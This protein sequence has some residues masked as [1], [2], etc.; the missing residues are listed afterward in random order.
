MCL[1][2]LA[3][4][5]S[6]PFS[7]V[8]SMFVGDR[9]W[10]PPT[11]TPAQKF[12]LS[13]SPPQEAKEGGGAGLPLGTAVAQS[14]SPKPRN[15]LL[16]KRKKKKKI[17]AAT[18]PPCPIGTVETGSVG[19]PRRVAQGWNT[20]R[21]EWWSSPSGPP[22]GPLWA[23]PLP[24]PLLLS[25]QTTRGGLPLTSGPWAM[26]REAGHCAALRW[27]GWRRGTGLWRPPHCTLCP[28]SLELGISFHKLLWGLLFPSSSLCHL[29][30]PSPGWK[31]ELTPGPGE[32]RGLQGR[33]A[34]GLLSPQGATAQAASVCDRDAGHSPLWE[35]LC[36]KAQPLAVPLPTALPSL[37]LIWAPASSLAVTSLPTPLSAWPFLPDTVAPPLRRHCPGPP[38]LPD[39]RLDR[40]AGL[41]AAAPTGSGDR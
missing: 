18:F 2:L 24:S 13:P 14:I 26:A 21:Q 36:L 29:L 7:V 25:P 20:L 23:S 8:S 4:L 31:A 22:P 37:A 11:V 6:P 16:P 33:W 32:G 9:R 40:A 15:F 35:S 3:L 1:P 39:G 28:P 17:P 10:F 5:P 38:W 34:P 12:P 41:G 30:P 27:W 19:F